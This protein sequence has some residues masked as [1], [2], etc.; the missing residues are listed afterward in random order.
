MYVPGGIPLVKR[1]IKL[2]HNRLF[3]ASQLSFLWYQHAVVS[4]YGM[5]DDFKLGMKNVGQIF[6][7][8]GTQT[9]RSFLETLDTGSD[10]A[11][12]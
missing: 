10:A 11:V 3:Q 4:G 2:P 6:G 8:S 1:L 7:K 9:K 5:L 12:H